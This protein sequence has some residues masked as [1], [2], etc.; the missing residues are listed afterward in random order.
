MRYKEP[1]F[2]QDIAYTIVVWACLLALWGILS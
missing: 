2:W 1:S